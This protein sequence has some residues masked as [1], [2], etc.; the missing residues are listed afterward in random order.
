MR[1]CVHLCF[2]GSKFAGWQKQLNAV[3]VQEVLENSLSILLKDKIDV[4]GCGRT[5]AGVHAINFLPTSILI[6]K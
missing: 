2:N 4:T 5:D 6:V 1:Y 3:S